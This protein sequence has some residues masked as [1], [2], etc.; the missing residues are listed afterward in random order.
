M[1]DYVE[2]EDGTKTYSRITDGMRITMAGIVGSYRRTTTKR[3]GASMAFLSIEDVYGSL[4]CVCFPAIYEKVKAFIGNDKIIKL[5]GKLEI[6]SEKGF[7]CIVDDIREIK[8]EAEKQVPQE[9]VAVEIPTDKTEVLWI[10]T[11]QLSDEDFN[12]LLV[13]LSNY[14][15]TTECKLVRGDKRYKLP[16][17]VNYCKGLLAELY[18]FLEQKNIKYID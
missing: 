8:T 3:T 13:T 11:S 9:N 15:G 14:E 2:D 16:Y 18:T 7:S 12:D 1:D 6:D 5:S 10:N 4:E 17:G